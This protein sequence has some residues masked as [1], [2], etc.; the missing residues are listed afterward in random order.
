MHSELFVISFASFKKNSDRAS[1]SGFILI[2]RLIYLKASISKNSFEIR[3]NYRSRFNERASFYYCQNTHFA[4]PDSH[5]DVQSYSY[6][7]QLIFMVR[8]KIFKS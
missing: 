5:S 1:R 3:L 6:R 8:N 7:R 2:E 4:T